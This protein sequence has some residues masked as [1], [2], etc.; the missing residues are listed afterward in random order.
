MF[1]IGKYLFFSGKITCIWF[2]LLILR[3]VRIKWWQFEKEKHFLTHEFSICWN[4]NK[5]RRSMFLPSYYTIFQLIYS[6]VVQFTLASAVNDPYSEMQM[7]VLFTWLYWYNVHIVEFIRNH[8]R[9]NHIRCACA[10]VL[11]EKLWDS[12]QL[13]HFGEWGKERDSVIQRGKKLFR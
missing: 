4:S 7:F 1:K 2:Y 11:T 13:L 12:K 5:L 6:D 9:H 10:C 8:I 3:L